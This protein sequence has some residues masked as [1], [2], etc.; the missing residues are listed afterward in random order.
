MESYPNYSVF[1]TDDY[2]QA[3]RLDAYVD[4]MSV[5]FDTDAFT[6]SKDT[7]KARIESRLLSELMLVDCQ[8]SGM[9]FTRTKSLIGGDG[10]D[11]YLIQ[12]F[13][14][15]ST[16]SKDAPDVSS[17]NTSKLII[18]DSAR[19]W[20]AFNSDFRNLTLIIPRRLLASKLSDEHGQHGKVLDPQTNP[21]AEI[22]RTHILS[23]YSTSGKIDLDLAHN[24]VS[25]TIDIVAA[26][27]NFCHPTRSSIN[28]ST[29][30]Y[31]LKLRIKYFIEKNLWNSKLSIERIQTEFNLTRSTLYRFFPNNEGG[32]M[33][34][35]RNRRL[36]LA[37]RKLAANAHHRETIA[38]IAFESGFEN[39]SSFTRAFKS[40]FKK[41]PS[42]VVLEGALTSNHISNT[43]SQMALWL[44]IL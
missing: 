34:Y 27:M 42:E 24:L 30:S 21:F 11:H 43:R 20:S 15:G 14:A 28:E 36:L 4:S 1:D 10:I 19:P 5:I 41:L 3:Q 22:L 25:P 31:A 6:Q 39:V 16:T 18:I 29:H 38:Q 17:C 33:S 35:V 26:A 7:F 23:L 12:L 9:D 40:H 37:Y 8:T 2:S 44:R 13:L 32:I